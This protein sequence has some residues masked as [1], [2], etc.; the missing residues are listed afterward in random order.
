MDKVDNIV[1]DYKNSQEKIV[2]N[3][4]E[5]INQLFALS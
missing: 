3:R 2:V 5:A 4:E 1:N